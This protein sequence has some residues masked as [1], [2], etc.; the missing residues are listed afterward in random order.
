LELFAADVYPHV[1]AIRGAA[2]A[3][4]RKWCAGSAM[5]CQGGGASIEALWFKRHRLSLLY[6]YLAGADIVVTQYGA[7]DLWVRRDR[8]RLCYGPGSKKVQEHRRIAMEFY[9]FC[10]THPRPED[11]PRVTLGV[12]HGHLDG[13]AGLWT[14]WV[15]GQRSG[16]EWKHSEPEFGWD[17]LDG[18]CRRAG[19]DCRT[20]EGKTD[21][22]GHPPYGQYDIVPIEVPL[23]SLKK[24]KCLMFLGWNTMTGEIYEKLKAF[25]K[26]GGHLIMAVP[27]LSTQTCR[28]KP[29]KLYKR[30]D[31]RDLFGVIV[32]GEGPRVTSG[33]KFLPP[34]YR[35]YRFPEWG[36]SDPLFIN[37][38]YPLARVELKG[39]RVLCRSSCTYTTPER[40]ESG[41]ALVEHRLGKGAALLITSWC[42]PGH[43]GMA[44][45]MKQ[46][47]RDIA[48]YE[49]GNIK[50]A[51]S[52][53]IK[54][55]VYEE[56]GLT[57][58]YLLNTDFEVSAA[59]N[60]W[61]RN[62]EIS[63]VTIGA[64]EMRIAYV[65]KECCLIPNDRSVHVV[66]MAKSRSGY[67]VVVTGK[68]RQEIDIHALTGR[69]T[70]A[71]LNGK[72]TRILPTKEANGRTAHVKLTGTR[73]VL[74]LA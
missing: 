66:S 70:E 27:H 60:I 73:D 64:C 16:D 41:P 25:V 43:R 9:D 61:I 26:G 21:F 34:A 58:I 14:P 29:I 3:Y 40:D 71:M 39:A 62:K 47:L 22:S 59:T 48:I 23:P 50:L 32:R 18:L 74:R 57:T 30:G 20:L 11:G 13:N 72:P 31:Y 38:E 2:K 49:Q 7:F 28:G 10:Q 54:Y 35:S 68:G 63:N 5:V 36:V 12:I 37:G 65:H 17:Y 33:H 15:W 19:W 52:D 4:G 55:A 45:L 1:A 46:L 44:P 53:R 6:S 51:G 24:Y 67:E 42:Y 56:K 8:K 69:I